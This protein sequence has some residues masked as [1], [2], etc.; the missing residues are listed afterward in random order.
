MLVQIQESWKL[1][2]WF[3]CLCG[4]KCYGYLVH[5]TLKSAYFKNEFM[6]W[7]DILHADCEAIIFG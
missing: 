2:Q 5:E 7:A 3:Y 1:F 4:Q 6:N